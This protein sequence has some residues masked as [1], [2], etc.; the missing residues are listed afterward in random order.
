[1]YCVLSEERNLSASTMRILTEVEA[2]SR[3]P[4]E[5]ALAYARSLN[6]KTDLHRKL[7]LEKEIRSELNL[8]TLWKQSALKRCWIG[9]TV[10]SSILACSVGDTGRARSWWRAL[11][12]TQPA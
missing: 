6:S 5:N 3:S 8:S 11:F 9:E 7:Y 12:T 10:A 1:V 2:K 4:I